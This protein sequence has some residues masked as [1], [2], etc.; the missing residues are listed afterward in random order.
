MGRRRLEPTEQIASDKL[1]D[2]YPFWWREEDSVWVADN[3]DD[4]APGFRRNGQLDPVSCLAALSFEFLVGDRTLVQGVQRTPWLGSVDGEGRVRTQCAPPHGTRRASAAEIAAELRIALENELESYCRNREP[5]IVLLSGG[6]DSRVMA[7][8]LRDLQRKGRVQGEIEAATWG[9][10]GSRD[11]Q[12]A[13][14]LAADLGWKWTH[15]LLESDDYWSNFD[16]CV[17]VLGSE[18]DPKHIHR[19]DAFQDRPPSALVL[20]AS[21]GDSV[22]RAEFGHRHVSHIPRLKGRDRYALLRRSVFTEALEGLEAELD[23]P[24]GLYGLRSEMGWREIER[25]AQYMRRMLCNTMCVIRQSC[26][27]EQLFVAPE[28]F[29]L[30]WSFDAECRTDRVYMELLR[31]IDPELLE[32]PWARTGTAYGATTL[33]GDALSKGFH[34]YGMWLR[35]DHAAKLRDMLFGDDTLRRLDIFDVPQI[36]WLFGEWQKERLQDDTTP[37]TQLSWLAVAA[38]FCRRHGIRAPDRISR[39]TSLRDLAFTGYARAFQVASRTTRGMR[40]E[41]KQRWPR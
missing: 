31:A 1:G 37:C 6:M 20:A 21:Y 28:V 40:Q 36:E 4:A 16:R 41:L 32:V 12:Y 14:R 11:V 22:G 15:L 7:S 18:V 3:A 39:E 9:M 2:C 27:L 17:R 5:I 38:E 10:E 30:M 13:E 24:R 33:S 35:R 8:V 26:G 34:R 25:Q 29:G 19:M 23:A